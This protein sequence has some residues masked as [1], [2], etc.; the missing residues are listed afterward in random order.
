LDIPEGND[1]SC[2]HGMQ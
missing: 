1:A 2:L